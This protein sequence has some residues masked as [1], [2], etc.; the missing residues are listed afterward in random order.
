MVNSDYTLALITIIPIETMMPKMAKKM[1][2]IAKAKLT[3]L[4]I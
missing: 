4:K 2:A 1:K 3:I